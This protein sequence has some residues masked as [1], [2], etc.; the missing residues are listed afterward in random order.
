MTANNFFVAPAKYYFGMQP[1]RRSDVRLRLGDYLDYSAIVV[2]K[3]FGHITNQMIWGTLGNTIAGD[4]V[5]AGSMHE[6]MDWTH[7][8]QGAVAPFTAGGALDLYKQISGWNGIPGDQSDAGVEPVSYANFRM[9]TGI[10]DAAG[11]V[12]K[13]NGYARV[14]TYDHL[15]AA[16]YL[17]GACAF[18]FNV[19]S[20]AMKQ[21]ENG[22]PWTDVGD[23]SNVGGHY[24]PIVG[25]NRAGNLIAVTWGRLQALDASFIT[26]YGLLILAYIGLDYISKSTQLTPEN[27]NL[28]QLRADL[29]ALAN[30]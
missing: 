7:A 29:A 25:R 11:G 30:G 10:A 16:A 18:C 28:A 14:T 21:F 12:H 23:Q 24:V 3:V 8:A 26:R 27:F 19:P 6:I 15:V 5:I 20:S 4:C 2:P 17:F 1:P 13:I 9:R 22:Q